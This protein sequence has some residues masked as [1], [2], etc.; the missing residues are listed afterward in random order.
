MA[1]L[2]EGHIRADLHPIEA[3]PSRSEARGHLGLGSKRPAVCVR[4]ALDDAILRGPGR[5][6]LTRVRAAYG[7]VHP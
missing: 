6:V 1:G 7:H 4:L 2:D 3:Q 5:H